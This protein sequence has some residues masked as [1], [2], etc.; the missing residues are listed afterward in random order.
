MEKKAVSRQHTPVGTPVFPRLDVETCSWG[1]RDEM[2]R[3]VKEE[4]GLHELRLGSRGRTEFD[5]RVSSARPNG[6]RQAQAS[7]GSQTMEMLL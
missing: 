5:K 4:V 2:G 3:G 7:G 1:Y 6:R